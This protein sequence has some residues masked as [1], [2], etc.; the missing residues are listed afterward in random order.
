M[1]FLLY[2]YDANKQSFIFEWARYIT[3]ALRSQLHT[4]YQ[5]P[6]CQDYTDYYIGASVTA[7]YHLLRASVL[8]SSQLL[9]AGVTASYRLLG[10][11]MMLALHSTCSVPGSFKTET[12][13]ICFIHIQQKDHQSI[14]KAD[15]S[16]SWCTWCWNLVYSSISNCKYHYTICNDHGKTKNFNTPPR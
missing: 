5:E 12:L 16:L 13:L 15:T 9:G 11:G 3:L 2:V 7:S 10:A 4:D 6:V 8:A 14:T 1:D